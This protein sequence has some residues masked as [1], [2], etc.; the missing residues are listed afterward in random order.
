MLDFAERK[1]GK[2]VRDAWE[3]FN[4]VAL[5]PPYEQNVDEKQIFSPTFCLS[6]I[7]SG[8][9]GVVEVSCGFAPVANSTPLKPE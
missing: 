6:G 2:V 8:P 9:R 3:D 4:Q 7:R 5:P 1:F